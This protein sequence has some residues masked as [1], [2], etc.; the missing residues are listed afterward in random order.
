MK[1]CSFSSKG[2]SLCHTERI[3]AR[4]LARAREWRCKQLWLKLRDDDPPLWHDLIWSPGGLHTSASSRQNTPQGSQNTQQPRPSQPWGGAAARGDRKG[5][6]QNGKPGQATRL[7]RPHTAVWLHADNKE[8]PL[9]WF[10]AAFCP[11]S[12]IKA[13]LYEEKKTFRVVSADALRLSY[14]GAREDDKC[15]AQPGSH[16]VMLHSDS[17]ASCL[18]LAKLSPHISSKWVVGLI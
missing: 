11:R 2:S 13:C 18:Y 14:R 15:K 7:H 16:M 8:M 4:A 17:V 9:I 6:E 10:L 1:S 5:Q 12:L 3:T